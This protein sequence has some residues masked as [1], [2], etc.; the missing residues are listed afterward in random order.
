MAVTA[1]GRVAIDDGLRRRLTIFAVGFATLSLLVFLLG[2]VDTFDRWVLVAVALVAAALALP[3]LPREVR[4]ARAA[5]PRAGASR[6]LVVTAAA[7]VLLDLILAAAP[8]TSGD[9]IAYHLSAPKL[10]LDAGHI[11][12]VWWSW[13][14]FQPF[15]AEMFFALALALEGGRAAMILGAAFGAFSAASVYGLTREL[16]G[17]TAAAI[18]SL[19]WVGQG[20][21]V[22]EATGGFVELLLA[23]FVAL[24]AWHVAALRRTGRVS[25]AAWAGLGAGLAAAVKYHGLI[26]LPVLAALA[27]WFG[28]GRRRAALASFAI[29]ACVAVPW[30]ARNWIVTGNPTYP[31]L[32]GVFGGKYLDAATRYDLDQSLN[33]TGIPG[34]ARLPIFPLEFLLHTDKYERGYAF[35]PA[36]FALP[37]YAVAVGSR[38]FR[39]IGLGILV[40]LVVW[41]EEMQQVTRYLLPILAFAAVL[42][43]W[44]AVR[45]WNARP[46]G[47][48]V[49]LAVA[50]IAVVP[51]VAI[52]GLFAWRTG[53]GALG[54][55]SEGRYVQRLTGTYDAFRWLD[56]RLPP[57]GRVLVGIRDLYWLDRP[58]AAYDVPLFNFG[59]PPQQ[60]VA[61]MRKYDVRYLAFVNGAL[62]TPLQHLRV[63]RLARL[64]V[65]FVTSRTL[66]R[67]SHEILDVW[68]W[69]DARGDPCRMPV[70]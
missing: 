39:L 50:L 32:A 9:A 58:Y 67:T 68:A 37:L 63:K 22:W 17:T 34:L 51:F 31:F 62:P 11:F 64:D 23:G 69:C 25:D 3:F 49:L 5:W 1:G 42:A 21:F 26:F 43:G 29:L 60:A 65:P 36:L 48:R 15:S 10:W 44:A 2:V 8:P 70:R 18:A 24:A 13:Q 7:I 56:T 66:G 33:A 14:S 6:W 47:R 38:A 46:L 57:H 53:A 61:R 12:P 30:Y 27:V 20:V 59:Q 35:S 45:L 54:V 55:E 4:A 16:A 19:L 41:W 28:N 40:Y 52:T